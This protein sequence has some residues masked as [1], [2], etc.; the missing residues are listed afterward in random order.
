MHRRDFM[1]MTG[2][3]LAAQAVPSLSAEETVDKPNLILIIADQRHY[4]LSR[5]TGFSLDTS[6]TLDRLQ[7]SGIGFKR[8]YCT[9]PLCVP[10]R[11]SMLTGRWPEAHHVRMNLQA[12]DAFF[13]Q[14]VHQVA[15]QHGYRTALSGK[16]HTYLTSNDLDV[17]RE[18]SHENGY[19]APDA[20]PDVKAFEQW[21]KG[22]HFNVAMEPKP[23]SSGDAD[24]VPHRLGG[25]QVHRRNGR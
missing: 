6:P 1:K 19:I 2:L 5:A 23:V 7:G 17:W 20:S 13:S 21:L 8:N 24:P 25:H 3:S 18:F 22:L 4:G 10:N 9:T 12:K 15:K 16:N 14:D 11:I